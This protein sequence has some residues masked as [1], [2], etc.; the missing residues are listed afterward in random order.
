MSQ[1]M[2]FFLVIYAIITTGAAVS[3]IYVLLLFSRALKIYI[4]KNSIQKDK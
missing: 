2:F 4:T 3:L 1:I